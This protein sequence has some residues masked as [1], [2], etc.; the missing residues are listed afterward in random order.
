MDYDYTAVGIYREVSADMIDMIDMRG[1]FGTS[2]VE[3]IPHYTEQLDSAISYARVR[4]KLSGDQ[5]AALLEIGALYFRYENECYKVERAPI[6]A[7]A[8]LSALADML[9]V[10]QVQD[11]D[12]KT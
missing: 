8:N 11:D 5:I 7:G 9:L 4:L 1:K 6:A 12:G 2:P 3:K 10:L